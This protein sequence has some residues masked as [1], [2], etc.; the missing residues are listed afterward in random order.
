MH[1]GRQTERQI[2]LWKVPSLTPPTLCHA[3]SFENY[4]FSSKL[5]EVMAHCQPSLT[6]T[7]DNSFNLFNNHVTIEVSIFGSH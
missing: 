6:P 4:V 3:L 1:L 5:A 7:F 2:G